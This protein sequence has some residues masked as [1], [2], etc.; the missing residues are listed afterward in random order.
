MINGDEIFSP[1]KKF[2][3]LI[4]SLIIKEINLDYQIILNKVRRGDKL[5]KKILFIQMPKNKGFLASGG[6]S[7]YGVGKL[8]QITET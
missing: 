8:R 1:M 2:F 5:P 3:Y 6:V 4:L 7:K